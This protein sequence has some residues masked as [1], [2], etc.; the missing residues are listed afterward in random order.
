MVRTD[1]TP[2]DGAG[3]DKDGDGVPDDQQSEATSS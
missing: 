3:G 1:E 2:D